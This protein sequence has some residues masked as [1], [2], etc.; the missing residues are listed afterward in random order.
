MDGLIGARNFDVIRATSGFLAPVEETRG[1][2]SERDFGHDAS[3][4]IGAEG[5]RVLHFIVTK[6][7]SF[8]TNRLAT[9][10]MHRIEP[11]TAVQCQARRSL[12]DATRQ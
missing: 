4:G 7:S 6:V 8:L 12:D 1:G 10:V 5:G 2:F 3:R 11:V 9:Q